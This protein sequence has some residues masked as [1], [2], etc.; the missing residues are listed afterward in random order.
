MRQTVST[1][2]AQE[3]GTRYDHSNHVAFSR[4]LEIGTRGEGVA[5]VVVFR[6]GVLFAFFIPAFSA[7]VGET[8]GWGYG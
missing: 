3:V 2:A 6:Y 7:Y 4:L 8:H 5:D 1:V